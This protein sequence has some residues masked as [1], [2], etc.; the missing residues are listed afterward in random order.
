MKLILLF[1][2]I[3]GLFVAE[4]LTFATLISLQTGMIYGGRSNIAYKAYS[5]NEFRFLK[6][7]F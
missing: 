1:K 5:G 2:I 3:F 6:V 4:N 7:M